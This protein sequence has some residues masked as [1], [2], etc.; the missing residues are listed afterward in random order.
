MTVTTVTRRK[1]LAHGQGI[2][3]PLI[4]ATTELDVSR[5]GVL[6]LTVGR[7]ACGVH[8]RSTDLLIRAGLE[9]VAGAPAHRPEQARHCQKKACQKLL[10][11]QAVGEVS[12]E[13]KEPT[14]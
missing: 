6:R 4:H 5:V 8:F 7:T 10:D 13:Q 9:W 2:T 14:T 12:S 1:H 3:D 11:I